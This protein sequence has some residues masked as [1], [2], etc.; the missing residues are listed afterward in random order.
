MGYVYGYVTVEN[1]YSLFQGKGEN[2]DPCTAEQL[3]AKA[4]YTETLGW[5]EEIWDFSEL[6]VAN[7]KI[8]VL[9]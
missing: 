9:K 5:S 4:F 7:G 2:G 6:D 1:S 3:N 8:P